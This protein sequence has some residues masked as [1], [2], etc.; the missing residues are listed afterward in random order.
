MIEVPWGVFFVMCALAGWGLVD[1][2]LRL[3]ARSP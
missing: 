1:L 2:V 3:I